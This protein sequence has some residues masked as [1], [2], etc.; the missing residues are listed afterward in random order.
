[1]NIRCP[2]LILWGEEDRLT[3]K[4][5]A[6]MMQVHID[7]STLKI[8]PGAGHMSTVEEPAF[9]NKAIIDF[10]SAIGQ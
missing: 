8:I 7:N 5:K 4:K 2:A 6:E 9:I 1:V 10:L 3:D